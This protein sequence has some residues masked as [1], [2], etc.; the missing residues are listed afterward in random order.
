[1]QKFPV[2]GSIFDAI[3]QSTPLFNQRIASTKPECA[4][5]CAMELDKT[6]QSALT[7]LNAI[8]SLVDW[9]IKVK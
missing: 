5:K 8:Q 7:V 4:K 1:M 6:V 2:F 9:N 3:Q